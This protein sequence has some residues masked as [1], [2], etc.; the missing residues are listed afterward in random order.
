MGTPASSR[1]IAP[2]SGRSESG[3]ARIHRAVASVG[4]GASVAARTP[5]ARCPPS[6]SQTPILRLSVAGPG[7]VVC[8]PVIRVNLLGPHLR[9][10]DNRGSWVI[11]QRLARGLH[12]LLSQEPTIA[13]P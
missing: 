8:S 5:S 11:H 10:G 9:D 7:P 6:F 2:S 1:W 12:A 3:T 4:A 13:M